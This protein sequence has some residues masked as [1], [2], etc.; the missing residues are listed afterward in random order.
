MKAGSGN[1]RR[2][3]R[4]MGLVTRKAARN[5]G[6]LEN[7]D[8]L[9]CQF[10]RGKMVRQ[11]GRSNMGRSR[12]RTFIVAMLTVVRVSGLMPIGVMPGAV[13]RADGE[14]CCAIWIGHPANWQ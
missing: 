13:H 11:Y 3:A 14:G 4:G 9:A 2:G 1:V 7:I 6:M 5:F 10:G 8:R 12:E